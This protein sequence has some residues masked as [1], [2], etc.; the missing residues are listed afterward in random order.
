MCRSMY[1][2]AALFFE[3]DLPPQ[4]KPLMLETV[5]NRPVLF[6]MGRRMAELGVRRFFVAAP[7]RYADK[8]RACLPAEAEIVVSERHDALMAFLDTG[9]TVLALPRVALP[10]AQA[11]VGMVYAAP[12]QSLREAW[13]LKLT[14]AVQDTELVPGWVPVYSRELLEELR[15]HFQPDAAE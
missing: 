1:T 5:Q 12:G 15:P 2:A 4:E 8:V 13:R 11:G 9:E 7:E 6:W 14:N 10:M 3:Q